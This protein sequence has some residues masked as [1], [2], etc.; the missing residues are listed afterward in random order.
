MIKTTVSVL[1]VPRGIGC[2][3]ERWKL[4]N[5]GR[6]LLRNGLSSQSHLGMT[7]QQSLSSSCCSPHPQLGFQISCQPP[8]QHNPLP[9]NRLWEPRITCLWVTEAGVTHVSPLCIWRKKK[10]YLYM[11]AFLNVPHFIDSVELWKRSSYFIS[12]N[13][14]VWLGFTL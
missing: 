6:M 9:G 8:H 11:A 12:R 4:Q 5:P 3:S 1:A 2:S 7:P 14:E 10:L 13:E